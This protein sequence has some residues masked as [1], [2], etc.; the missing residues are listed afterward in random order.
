MS[1]LY[2]NK[3]IIEIPPP[4]LLK[5]DSV[6]HV[7]VSYQAVPNVS[8]ILGTWR[9]W[10]SGVWPRVTRSGCVSAATNEA[11]EVCHSGSFQTHELSPTFSRL[12]TSVDAA[13]KRKPLKKLNKQTK[14][15]EIKR[16]KKKKKRS[17]CQPE[18]ESQR[19]AEANLGVDVEHGK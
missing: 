2:L 16:K 19:W 10:Q 9:E 8:P 11:S 1:E 12:S 13:F 14:H 5:C 6:T 3:D 4:N 7:V 17:H 18:T 15:K